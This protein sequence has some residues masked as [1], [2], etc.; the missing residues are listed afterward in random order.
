MLFL[1]SHY[2]QINWT[3]TYVQSSQGQVIICQYRW[4]PDGV[5]NTTF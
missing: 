4:G 1:F 2:S 3:L 5:A